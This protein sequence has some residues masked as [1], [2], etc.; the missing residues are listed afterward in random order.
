MLKVRVKSIPIRYS[1]KIYRKGDMINVKK[2]HYNHVEKYTDLIEE[3]KEKKNNITE[4][5]LDELSYN[6]L[7]SFIKEQGLNIGKRRKHEDI[8]NFAKEELL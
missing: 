1:G 7:K 5:Y 3:V 8:L 4:K 6:D 2:E